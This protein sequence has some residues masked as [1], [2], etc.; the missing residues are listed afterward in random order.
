MNK[1]EK[2]TRIRLICEFLNKGGGKINEME[3]SVNQQLT[4]HGQKEIGRRTLVTCLTCLRKGDFDHSL[5]NKLTRSK[6][7]IFKVLVINKSYQWAPDSIKP[8]FGDLDD[9]ERFT[10]PFL[11]GILRRYE[12]IPAVQ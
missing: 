6:E 5:K 9:E 3:T 1:Q 11:A 2:N 8:E 4:D 10:L 12:S 7:D